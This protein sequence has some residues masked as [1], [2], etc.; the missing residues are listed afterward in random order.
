MKL[1][2]VLFFIPLGYLEIV[3]TMLTEE[4]KH[5]NARCINAKKK[6][7]REENEG[8]LPRKSSERKWRIEMERGGKGGGGRE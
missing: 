3:I 1:K 8:N 5:K 4:K 2:I 6:K 7:E